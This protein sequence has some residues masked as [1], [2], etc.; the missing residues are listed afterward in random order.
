MSGRRFAV[1]WDAMNPFELIN[2]RSGIGK[3]GLLEVRF[4]AHRDAPLVHWRPE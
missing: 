2:A 4:N 1:A 3:C